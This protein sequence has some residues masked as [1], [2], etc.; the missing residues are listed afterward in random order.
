MMASM[1]GNVYGP[2][3]DD[4]KFYPIQGQARLRSMIEIRPDWCVSRQRVWGVPLPLFVDK[5][6]QQPLRDLEVINRIADIYE[7]EG[8]DAWFNSKASR[9]LGDKYSS[10]DFEQ[11]KDVVE[12]WFDSGST[13]S[14][15]LE[16][17]DDLIWPA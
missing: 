7:K 11:V 4:T 1:W 17:R 10:A 6:N 3:V 8:A 9:F 2:N 12:V 15:V 5:K 13:H 16:K 14:F